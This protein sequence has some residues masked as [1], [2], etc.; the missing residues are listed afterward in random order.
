MLEEDVAKVIQYSQN[1]ENPK[2]HELIENWRKAKSW[3]ITDLFDNNL[4]YQVPEK[5]TFELDETA[6]KEKYS[7]FRDYVFDLCCDYCLDSYLRSINYN[8]FFENTLTK[9]RELPN[10]KIVKKDMKFLRTLRFLID[11]VKLL[12][13][14]QNYASEIIQE[15][16]IEGYLCFSVHPLDFLSSSENTLNWRS[17]HSL[18]GEYRAGNLSYM[19][20][21]STIIA[22]IRTEKE[23]KLPRFPEDVPWNNK[24][25]RC[26]LFFNESQSLIFAGRQYPFSASNIL[27]RV[28]VELRQLLEKR[29]FSWSPWYNDY[30][31]SYTRP[32]GDIVYFDDAE[33][34]PFGNNIYEKSL[35]IKDVENSNHF[36]DLLYSCCYTHPYYMYRNFVSSAKVIVGSEVKCLRCGEKIIDGKDSMMCHECECKYGNSD[37]DEYRTCDC[38]GNRFW[39]KDGVYVDS[40]FLCPDCVENETFICE[41]CGDRCFN[42]DRKYDKMKEK[43]VCTNCYE[44]EEE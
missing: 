44:E 38:C 18:D 7:L 14:I 11:D 37:S 9:D 36:N 31:E 20:D 24:K 32:N 33:Y 5:I 39:Y 10:G 4:I 15:N 29:N 28:N 27:N 17:C 12:A 16:K 13:D 23:V 3:F 6:K 1:I 21:S 19:Q 30:I 43:F 25:W 34:L 40:N 42:S 35:L 2:I 26:L 8:E 22:Y 41:E